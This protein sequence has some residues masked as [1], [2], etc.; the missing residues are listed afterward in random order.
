MKKVLISKSERINTNK[1]KKYLKRIAASLVAL[2]MSMA[3]LSCGNSNAV[4]SVAETTMIETKMME[5]TNKAETSGEKKLGAGGPQ[6]RG[7]MGAGVNFL[8]DTSKANLEKI[9]NE[10]NDINKTNGNLKLLIDDVEVSVEWEDNDSVNAI[11][12]LA[13]NGGLTINTH[14]YGG[15]E[16]VGEIGQSIVS[17]NVQMTTEPGDIVL[18]ADSNIVVFYGSNSWSYTKLGKIKDKNL[19]ELKQLLDKNN[20]VIKI[21]G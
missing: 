18:Y 3:L 2:T 6:G 14:Q 12:E 8:D 10:V 5:E 11:K 9:S 19:S 20:V 4:N 21:S 7:G 17:N 13:K 1:V 15:F 16:Q